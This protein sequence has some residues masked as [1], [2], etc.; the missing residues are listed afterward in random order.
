MRRLPRVKFTV[1]PETSVSWPHQC[2]VC[3]NA[4]VGM[5][6]AHASSLAS[7]G[8]WGLGWSIQYHKLRLEFPLCLRHRLI[9]LITRF[10]YFLSFLGLLYSAVLALMTFLEIPERMPLAVLVSVPAI[11][12][13]IFLYCYFSVPVRVSRS[14][15]GAIVVSVLKDDYAH[16]FAR[17]NPHIYQA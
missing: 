13:A 3:G 15:S 9:F 11:S 6:K 17:A 1:S 8:W 14:K 12:L 16:L 4:R 7:I 10:F 2:V 5:A